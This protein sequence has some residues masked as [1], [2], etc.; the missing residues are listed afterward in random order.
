MEIA[1]QKEKRLFVLWNFQQQKGSILGGGKKMCDTRQEETKFK[2]DLERTA[3]R[4]HS[5]AC[6][7]ERE[8]RNRGRELEKRRKSSCVV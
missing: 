1:T 3:K 5:S 7:V 4:A 8:V 6:R 2:E